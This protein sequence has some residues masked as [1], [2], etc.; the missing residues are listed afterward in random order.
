[1]IIVNSTAVK[2]LIVGYLKH[3]QF[4]NLLLSTA[5]VSIDFVKN[6]M[7]FNA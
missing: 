1:M 3:E 4:V 7:L 6:P 5:Y 2:I